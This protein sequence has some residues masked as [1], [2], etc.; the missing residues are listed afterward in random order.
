VGTTSEHKHWWKPVLSAHC[1]EC[2]YNTERDSFVLIFGYENMKNRIAC[3]KL[4]SVN[5][6]VLVLLFWPEAAY[7]KC[8][9]ER[10]IVWIK[11][12]MSSE[13][14]GVGLFVIFINFTFV[15]VNVYNL[16]DDCFQFIKPT[17]H[18]LKC[19]HKR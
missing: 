12:H 3:S 6:S 4:I 15:A 7:S 18:A 8:R 19:E 17:F 11:I 16:K 1:S 14:F 2:L 5:I 10:Y 9:V 13:T